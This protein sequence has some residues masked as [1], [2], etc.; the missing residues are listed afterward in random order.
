MIS[1]LFLD[2]YFSDFQSVISEFLKE[3]KNKNALE[4]A[5][6]LINSSRNKNKIFIIGNGGSASVAE[7]IAIDL[8]KNAGLNAVSFSSASTVTTFAND[9]GYENLFKKGLEHYANNGDILIAISGTGTSKN[10]L[11]ACNYAKENEIKIITLSGFNYDN[12]LSSLGDI[13]FWINS[14]AFGYLEI[15]HTLLLHYINDAII[16]NAEYMIR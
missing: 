10:I 3:Y 1:K 14:K 16:G 15:I 5:V 9:F 13:N 6:T 2:N 7:H 4:A 8:T 12:P 11:K